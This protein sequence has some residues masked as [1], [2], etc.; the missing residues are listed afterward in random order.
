[1]FACLVDKLSLY[2][3][4]PTCSHSPNV[5][6][7]RPNCSHSPKLYSLAQPVLTRSTCTHSHLVPLPSTSARRSF[8]HTR[9]RARFARRYQAEYTKRLINKTDYPEFDLEGVVQCF[10][11]CKCCCCED[12]RMNADTPLCSHMC[13]V[14]ALARYPIL[15]F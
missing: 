2:S 10:L 3:T 12:R 8:T 6:S 15:C 4:R 11:E 7:T 1:M 5:Y 14:E 13:V 9:T